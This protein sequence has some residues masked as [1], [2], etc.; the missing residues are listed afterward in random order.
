MTA[1][2]FFAKRVKECAVTAKSDQSNMPK[3]VVARE[4]AFR[5]HSMAPWDS[6]LLVSQD[7]INK[8]CFRWRRQRDAHI[9]I[10]F[11]VCI[12]F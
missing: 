5:R 9:Y 3:K 12:L 10:Y 8:V 11:T 7:G 6:S 2:L 4:D 1:T